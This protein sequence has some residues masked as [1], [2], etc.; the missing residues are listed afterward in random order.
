MPSKRHKKYNGGGWSDSGMISPGNLAHN[1]YTGAGKDCP[2][3]VVRPGFISYSGTGLPGLRGGSRNRR[4]LRK[5]SQRSKRGGALGIADY[6]GGAPVESLK[7]PVNA[8][9]VPS[10]RAQQGGR[11]GSFPMGPLSP[12]G[13]G[14]SG[15][16]F[17]P[18][19]CEKGFMRGGMAPLSGSQVEVGQAD[20]MRYMAPSAGYR[21]D[22]Q[23]FP[24]G[25]AVGGLTIQTPYAAGSMNPACLKTGGRRVHKHTRRCKHKKHSRKHKRN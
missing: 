19:P 9:G 8:P 25:G 15:I 10:H 16:S 18:I 17:A 21:N 2:G 22:F 20:S 4:S 3:E 6:L 11:W 23:A 5:R 1:P 14:A 12:N 7:L 24:A 13:V